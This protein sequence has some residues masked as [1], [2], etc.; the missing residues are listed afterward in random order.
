MYYTVVNGK[1]RLNGMRKE[2]VIT[3]IRYYHNIYLQ[4]LRQITKTTMD[5]R[6]IN[7]KEFSNIKHE[8]SLIRHAQFIS[9]SH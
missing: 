2:V 3:Y 1:M 8:I 4:G 6:P 7:D 5:S 9:I